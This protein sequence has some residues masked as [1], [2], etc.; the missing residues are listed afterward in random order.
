MTVPDRALPPQAP[1]PVR[2]DLEAE[3]V[4]LTSDLI[5]ID[6]SNPPGN[7]TPAAELVA[8][9]LG[10][11]GIETELA[12]PDPD[13]LNLIARI[14][15][16]G[17]GPSIMLMG[18]T[19]VVPAPTE[20]WTVNPF[21]A[22]LRDGHLVGRGAVDMKDELA[23]RAVAMAAFA[24]SGARPKGDIVLVAESDEERNVSDVGMS[25][26]V[27]ERPELKSDFALNES[28]GSLLELADGGRA[29]TVSVGEKL[30]TSLRIRVHGRA[31]HASV[32]DRDKNTL[33]AA[34]TVVER[35]FACEVPVIVSDSVRRSLDALGAPDGSDAERLDWMGRQHPGLADLVP[36]MTTT[37]ITPTGLEAGEPANVIPP[38]A[39]VICDCRALPGS[40]EDDIR[41]QI[42]AAI[43][44]ERA[45]GAEIEYEV[46]FL[47]PLAGGVESPP[48]TE[49]YAILERY[50][51]ERVPGA[52]LLPLVTPGFTDSHWVRQA[53]GT[54]AYGFAP[55]L[56]TDLDVYLDSMHGA[57]ERIRT[58]DLVTM[59][60]FHL[61]ALN[62]L[63]GA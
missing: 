3:V 1:R 10:A 37:S 34:S 16:S 6:T 51:E 27:R 35:L 18:H 22:V 32:P 53:F 31:G 8:G 48:D 41:A 19:D 50:V 60:E 45:S 47:E 12:G 2:D 14:R 55:V 26:L 49:L 57:D 28:G 4:Q 39:D 11:A 59:A 25:W 63:V 38:F 58:D 33:R 52:I 29:V 44:P 56:A 36:A 43:G 7:E 5:R 13:R 42:A 17:E 20:N 9:Y 21:D 40:T 54:V 24:R 23:A 15:G 46:E 62:A 61:F 30:V